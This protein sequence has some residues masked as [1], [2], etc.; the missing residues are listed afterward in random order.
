M[1][2]AALYAALMLAVIQPQDR[3]RR[4]HDFA[5]ILPAADQ[6]EIEELLQDV[7]RKTTAQV[8]VV[9]V[10]SL[11]GKPV[12]AYAHELFQDWGI[13]RRETNNGVLFLIAPHERR[14]WITT[15]YGI[16][17]LLTDEIAGQIRDS[18]VIPRFK[19]GDI[20]NG[21][22][23]G[24]KSIVAVLLS[25][26]AA[27]RG[28]PNSGPMLAR[29]ARSR[30]LVAT[31]AVA[32]AAIVLC[33]LGALVMF[34]RLYSTTAFAFISTLAAVLIAAASYFLWQTPWPQQPL[35][36]FGSATSLTAA[37]WAFNLVQYRRFGPHACSKCGT[38]LQL[39]SEMDDDPK[40]SSV[41]RLEEKIGSI[42]YD[43]WVCP[44]CLNQDTERYI[45]RFSGFTE[46]PKCHARAYQED[47][48]RVTR[49]ATT[50]HQ[51]I[52][53]VDGHCAACKLK[54][55]RQ[56]LLPVLPTPVVTS[57]SSGGSFSGGGG[58]GGGGGGGGFGGGSSGG[59]G[60]G[61]GW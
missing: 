52:A 34:R 38:Q 28:D 1:Q 23:E 19:Q 51:G 36:L 60:A 27:A 6:S 29:T 7:E 43:V 54:T 42:D 37:A 57:G 45:Q 56:I 4:V 40:L 17:P 55:S 3:T 16:E 11:D 15:G 50:T 33:G 9:T 14:M 30:S 13:G 58:W 61:G 31:T 26:P 21:I 32:G 59:G 47:P 25:D 44:A 8:A 53:F 49:E 18:D 39:L 12:E 5:G 10:N 2:I 22:R 20:P 35:V 24:A 46:C 41:Q 48:Q